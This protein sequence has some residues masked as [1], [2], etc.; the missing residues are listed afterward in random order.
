MEEKYIPE[1]A[2]NRRYFNST[3]N[4]T[5]ALMN[6]LNDVRYYVPFKEDES[7]EFTD[8]SF[9]VPITFGN[10]E[11]SAILED[12]KEKDIV[13]GNI[14]FLP[15][16]VLSFNGMTKTPDRQTQKHQTFKEKVRYND[17]DVLD[18]SY[19]SIAYDFHFTLL[20]Q[21]RGLTQATQITEQILSYFN[22]SMAIH[23][24]EFPLFIEMTE[25]QL[26]TEDPEFEIIEEFENE[27]IN[28]INVSFGLTI[29]GNIY[30]H[31]SYQAPIH[32]VKIALQVWD[33]YLIEESKMA[34][35]FKYDVDYKETHKPYRET[36]RYF[37]G[38]IKKT[39]DVF[40]P[41]EEKLEELRPDYQPPEV[42]LDLAEQNQIDPDDI[43]EL[44]KEEDQSKIEEWIK[45]R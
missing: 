40:V 12:I 14:N 44:K 27:Q 11:K 28:I 39:N 25:T 21:A 4:Y 5:L 17:Q 38:T 29:R 24:K 10:Y 35:Y 45:K 34:T 31:I 22:P 8:K 37:D 1:D 20:L 13:S 15:R 23:L 19:N 16:L 9:K 41:D 3:K 7:S 32:T 33:D 18:L 43:Y 36:M 2:L 6:A 42:V 30:S 26:M